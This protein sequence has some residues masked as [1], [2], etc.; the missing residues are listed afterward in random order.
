MVRSFCR[1]EEEFLSL[2]KLLPAGAN[3]KNDIFRNSNRGGGGI[4]KLSCLPKAGSGVVKAL[5]SRAQQHATK[6]EQR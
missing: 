4:I 5:T 1:R 3:N 6:K 2:G